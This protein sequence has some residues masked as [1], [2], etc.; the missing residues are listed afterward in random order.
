MHRNSLSIRYGKYDVSDVNV[1][2]ITTGDPFMDEYAL[3]M[4]NVADLAKVCKAH[5]HPYTP[6]PDH[7]VR[8]TSLR[9]KTE[10]CAPR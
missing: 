6:T 1:A 3:V 9:R 8:R 2:D 7:S 5:M 10:Q 4:G